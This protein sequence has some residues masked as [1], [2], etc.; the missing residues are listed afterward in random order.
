MYVSD[1]GLVC[2]CRGFW[3]D[4]CCFD[5]IVDIDIIYIVEFECFGQFDQFFVE[6]F[7]GGVCY[8]G[9]F[10]INVFVIILDQE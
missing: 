9:G 7:L 3:Q 6:V 10:C 8:F 4:Y 5:C 1:S 2:G